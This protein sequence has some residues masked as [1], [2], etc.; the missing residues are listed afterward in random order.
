VLNDLYLMYNNL[1]KGCQVSEKDKKSKVKEFTNFPKNL[2][3]FMT[4]AKM[5]Q[6]ELAQRCKLSNVTI[7][8]YLS[9]KRSPNINNVSK[10][11]AALN[12]KIEDLFA[13]KTY[14]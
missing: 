6:K 11:A 3:V 9:G 14:H 13:E 10:I 5:S 12:L 1:N 8:Y 7:N 2:R 4:I